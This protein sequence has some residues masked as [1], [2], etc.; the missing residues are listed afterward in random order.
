VATPGGFLGSVSGS[1]SFPGIPC[2]S[3][4]DVTG[5]AANQSSFQGPLPADFSGSCSGSALGQPCVFN[6][7]A[8]NRTVVLTCQTR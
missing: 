3:R 8:T 4:V 6:P 7:I 1:R 5:S 2:T